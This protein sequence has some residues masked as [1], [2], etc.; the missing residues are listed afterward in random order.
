MTDA[1]TLLDMPESVAELINTVDYSCVSLR[2]AD[3]DSIA[4][5][6]ERKIAAVRDSYA[7]T[8]KPMPSKSPSATSPAT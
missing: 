7:P 5:M 2:Q 6:L 3:F 4:V 1:Q 8:E